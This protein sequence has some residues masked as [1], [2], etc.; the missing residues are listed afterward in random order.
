MWM[1]EFD[2]DLGLLSDDQMN[3]APVPFMPWTL[4]P[5]CRVHL[6]R[7]CTMMNVGIYILR[8]IRKQ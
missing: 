6:S 3:L 5:V 1:T 8:T 2:V 7:V 4:E